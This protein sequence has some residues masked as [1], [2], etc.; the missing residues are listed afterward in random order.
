MCGAFCRAGLHLMG[1]GGHMGQGL[2][3]ARALGTGRLNVLFSLVAG[4]AEGNGDG[5]RGKPGSW[6]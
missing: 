2:V 4:A 6:S 3:M 1:A 5:D